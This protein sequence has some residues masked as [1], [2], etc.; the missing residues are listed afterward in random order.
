MERL[1]ASAAEPSG[2]NLIKLFS[3]SLMKLLS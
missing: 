3:S 1:S 2:V